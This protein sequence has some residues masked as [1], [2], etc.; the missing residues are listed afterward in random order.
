MRDKLL[1]IFM[2]P[3]CGYSAEISEFVENGETEPLCPDC[4]E[5]LTGDLILPEAEDILDDEEY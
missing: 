2:C 4:G 1:E 3:Y 5:D